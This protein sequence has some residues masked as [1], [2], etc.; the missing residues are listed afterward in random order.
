[1]AGRLVNNIKYIALS[2][3]DNEKE[4][5]LNHCL[6]YTLKDVFLNCNSENDTDK[7]VKL[8]LCVIKENN[9]EYIIN[10]YVYSKIYAF[11]N[12]LEEKSFY[13]IEDIFEEDTKYIEYNIWWEQL[14]VLIEKLENIII[15]TQQ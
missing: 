7:T 12:L 6:L 13:F 4:K 1:M 3:D 11:L 5:S 15:N 9:N 14:Q 2:N 10:D 8:I